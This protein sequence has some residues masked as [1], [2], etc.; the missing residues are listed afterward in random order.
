[1]GSIGKEFQ[2]RLSCSTLSDGFADWHKPR[3]KRSNDPQIAPISQIQRVTHE[4]EPRNLRTREFVGIPWLNSFK[5]KFRFSESEF[6]LRDL[7]NLRF[8]LPDLG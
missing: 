6:N 7:R 2:G 8:Q 3:F 4:S 1:M 5:P